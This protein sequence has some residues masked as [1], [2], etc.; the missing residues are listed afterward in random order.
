[1]CHHA[2]V[3]GRSGFIALAA[4]YPATTSGLRRS[5]RSVRYPEKSLAKDATLSATPSINPSCAGPAPREI[6]NAGSTQ[7]AISE[8]VSFRKDVMPKAYMLR[9]ADDSSWAEDGA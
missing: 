8:A 4:K 7:Y 2:V 1:M 6:R 9:A 5:R 3:M